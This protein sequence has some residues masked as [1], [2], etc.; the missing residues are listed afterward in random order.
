MGSTSKKVLILVLSLIGVVVVVSL[1]TNRQVTSAN[2]VNL[3]GSLSATPGVFSVSSIGLGEIK[4]NQIVS[5]GSVVKSIISDTQALQFTNHNNGVYSL[6]FTQ[7]CSEGEILKSDGITFLCS[8][9]EVGALALG[10]VT[11]SDPETFWSRS[12]TSLSPTNNNDSLAL[13]LGAISTTGPITAGAITSGL[14]N[15]QTIS[16]AANFTGSLALAG[17]LSTTQVQNPGGTNKLLLN[18]GAPNLTIDLMEYSSDGSAQSAWTSNAADGTGG[19]ITHSGGYTIHTFTSSGTFAPPG[20]GNVEVLVIGGGGG[21][22]GAG[23][24]AGGGG[25]GGFIYN[26]SYAVSGNVSI[27]VGNGG[28]GRSGANYDTTIYNGQ[29]SVFSSLTASGGGGGS[30]GNIAGGNG[31]SG[32]GGNGGYTT[33]GGTATPS[34]QGNNGGN[35]TF[36][37]PEYL[38]GGGGG[39]G[40]V[41]TAGVGPN[42]GGAGGVGLA[43]SISGSSVYYSGG[44]GG[45]TYTSGTG[46]TGGNGGG[47]NGGNY[48]IT[49]GAAGTT[50]KGG[51][52]GGGGG[53]NPYSSGGN[54]GSGIV[55]VRYLTPADLVDYSENTI[56]TQGSYAL[57]F[58][59]STSALNK[60]LTKSFAPVLNLSNQTS[61]NFDLRAS[62]TGSNIKIGM[63]DLGGTTTEI[64]PNVLTADT[65]QAVSWDISGV[66]NA[67]KDSIDSI[68]VTIVNAGASNTA[69]L[70]NLFSLTTLPDMTFSTNS[71][72]RVRIDNA[73]NVGIG[74]SVPS[75]RLQV[76]GGGL[77]VG[78]DA[79]CN[80]DNN[81]EG[82]VYSSSVSMTTYDLAEN[83]PTKDQTLEAEEVVAMDS[84]NGVFVSRA[85]EPYSRKI[86]GVISAKPGLLLGG[87]NGN[88]Y[89]NEKQVA[90][91]LSGRVP[92]KIS[93]NS[94]AI[95]IGD[96]LTAST[97]PGKAM[98]ATRSGTILGR[99]LE[100]W[101]PGTGKESVMVFV[102]SGQG[103]DITS[104]QSTNNTVNSQMLDL[105]TVRNLAVTGSL[106]VEGDATFVGKVTVTGLLDT[107]GGVKF[108]SN[109]IGTVTIPAGAKQVTVT[110]KTSLVS[111]PVVNITPMK[112]ATS[113][114][115]V[116]RVTPN[117]FVIVLANPT[118]EDTTFNWM[119]FP[120]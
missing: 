83:Y 16:S 1:L 29:N 64:T 82:V 117:G 17:A 52:G 43:S 114:Y 60:T 25:A 67:N 20:A 113:S 106:V 68:I 41:G 115:G 11:D 118:T 105:T 65:Y 63:H 58:V 99:A 56:K 75:S 21:G 49:N 57:K 93:Q 33:S 61:I 26:S 50:N 42:T 91:A 98:K 86:L 104:L 110:F 81:T 94:D 53:T 18:D 90:V 70:D 3:S 102:T 116:D 47:G 30:S 87:F 108:S 55:I 12:G 71:T 84:S 77:C 96:Y 38:G 39:A 97:E 101:S 45:G 2:K 4:A 44:G 74:S 89:T 54:G 119:A 51:G 92:V 76:T 85:S 100:N 48:H 69:Y 5:D 8:N 103:N 31:G 72:E 9:D 35:G 79:N 23:A 109:N 19:T 32:G 13:G 107:L 7:H 40:A 37:N 80:S 34:G 15:G 36:P 10:S 120:S 24:G 88:Q 46:G 111:T 59:A 22:G 27:T 14:I 66:S 62:R 78:S 112:I 6:D 73:G 28:I 95:A